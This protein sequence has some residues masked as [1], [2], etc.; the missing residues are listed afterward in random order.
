[1]T[2]Y[3]IRAAHGGRDDLRPATVGRGIAQPTIGKLADLFGPRKIYLAGPAVVLSGGVLPALVTTF[4]GVLTARILIG[5]GTSA[6]YPSAITLIRDQSVRHEVE[7]PPALLS[8]LSI[9]SL[10]AAA[11]GPV[12]GGILIET[13][14]WK[15]IFLVN[16]PPSARLGTESGLSRISTFLGAI[17]SSGVIGLTFGVRPTDGG[18]HTIG[19]LTVGTTGPAFLL[20]LLDRALPRQQQTPR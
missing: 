8:A 2:S 7:T 14:S 4:P 1:M 17:V 10:T 5:I 20:A 15:A 18:I 19:W 12:L 6:A 11:L 13:I 16:V 3:P 9:A